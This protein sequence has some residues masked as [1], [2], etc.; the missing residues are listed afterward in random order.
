MTFHALL[1]RMLTSVQ[2]IRREPVVLFRTPRF[3]WRAINEGPRLTLRRIKYITDPFRFSSSSLNY[4]A[5]RDKFG[6]TDQEKAAMTAWAEALHE[7]LVI[8]LL[9]PVFNP[10]PEWLQEAIDS[11]RSQLYP[12]WQLC[13]ADDCSTDPR[14]RPLL[15]AA[16]AADPRIQVVFRDHNGHICASSNS[17]LELVQ[18][19]WMAL[20]DHDD[21]LPDEALIWV[22]KA[23]TDHPDACLFYSDEDKIGPEGKPFDPYFK[24]DWNPVLME[25]QNMFCH[26]GVYSTELV[27]QVGGFR[28]G[29]E[30]SQDHDLVLR[31]SEQV[32]RD[33]IVHIP[34]V[35]Y[36]WRVHPQ[37]TSSGVSAK[38]YSIKTAERAI[39]E[40]LHRIDLPLERMRWSSSGFRPKL[41]LPNPAPRVSVIIPTRNGIEV[42]APCLTSLLECTCYP[43]LEVVV[44]DN[45]SDEPSTLHLLADLEQKGRIK[46]LR[47]PSPFNYSALNNR[48]VQQTNSELI[49]LLNNDIEV[50]DP[51]WLEELVVQVLR[52]GVGAVGAK[53]LYPDRTIQHGGVVLGVGGV[54]G[55]AHHRCHED[56]HG[57]FSRAQLTQE[58]T[59]VTAACLLVRRSHYEA[60]GG[61]NEEQ[62]KVAFNDVDFC[63]KLREVGLRNI[64]VAESKLIHHESVSRGDDLSG[65]KAKRFESEALWMMQKWSDQLSNDPYYNPNLS[66]DFMPFALSSPMSL[67]SPPRLKRWLSS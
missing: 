23:V 17:A 44:V 19:P 28:E 46:V 55:H 4:Q 40:H 18:A 39:T 62:L 35:L 32:R 10:K 20:L 26:L 24:G 65:E 61:L 7:P 53:L 1:R 14:I 38:S 9:M 15:E 45:G 50:I 5:W 25:A 12:H 41:A 67:S 13:I 43:D 6:T 56:E 48:A 49:C 51:G 31:C 59:A 34:R 2:V 54:A 8:A 47:D 60:V 37:S 42:L 21:L 29:F 52:P 27:R 57:Y 16:M 22:A 58:M 36:H 3:V 33:Q 64:F 66:L 30:G 63:L 11:V